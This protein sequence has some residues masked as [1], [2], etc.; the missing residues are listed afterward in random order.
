MKKLVCY[1]LDLE[2]DFGGRINST[3]SLDDISHFQDVVKKNKIKLTTFVAGHMFKRRNDVVKKLIDLGSEFEM[4]SYSHNPYHQDEEFEIKKSKEVY[5]KYF[6][7]KPLGYRAPKG[8]ISQEGFKIL[9][10]H[11][12]K[13]DSSIYPTMLPGRYNNLGFPLL[14]FYYKK[15]GLMEL[16]FSVIPL[17]KFPL[18]MGYVQPIGLG[19][20]K[21]LINV[22]GLP[23]II[24][25]DFHFWNLYK[26][27]HTN[28][29]S[30]KWK[31][32]LA[33]NIKQGFNIFEELVN[34]FN[35]RGYNPIYMEDLYNMMKKKKDLVV[36]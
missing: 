27:T 15:Y 28:K 6:G 13:F 16:P 29:L 34:M 11:G 5:T 14:P 25:F 9:S 35:K 7:K 26:P 30:P 4:H 22:F 1:T 32:L 12:F 18:A 21:Q 19:I 2:P 36:Y 33:R 23:E 17:I 8:I 3:S 24:V 20:T 10:K 31:F